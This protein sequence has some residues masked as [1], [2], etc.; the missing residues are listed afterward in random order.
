M[1]CCLGCCVAMCG[2][3]VERSCGCCGLNC[4]RYYNKT[5]RTDVS[6]VS[7]IHYSKNSLKAE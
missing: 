4:C 2:E 7:D 3:N 6:I 1:G 5:S